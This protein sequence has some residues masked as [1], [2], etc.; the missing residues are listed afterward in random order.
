MPG[1]VPSSASTSP[2]KIPRQRPGPT[3]QPLT[4]PLIVPGPVPSSASTPPLKIPRRCPGP[5]GQPLATP[6]IVPGPVPSSASTPPSKIP[7]R[8]PGPS[9][10]PLATPLIVPGPVPSSANTPPLKKPRRRP[11]PSGQPL[12]EVMRGPVNIRN[13]LMTIDKE[14]DKLCS[15]SSHVFRTPPFHTSDFSWTD[16]SNKLSHLTPLFW[17][18]LKQA[19]ASTSDYKRKTSATLSSEVA[20]CVLAAAILLK[21]RNIH[22]SSLAVSQFVA[23][24]QLNYGEYLINVIAHAYMQCAQSNNKNDRKFD[25]FSFCTDSGASQPPALGCCT[26]YTVQDCRYFI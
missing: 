15:K 20:T 18:I 9:G 13:V 7:R 8:H 1:P 12:A 2:S 3:G 24:Q 21:S 14:C 5:T 11:G 10:Q 26:T 23:W 22:L 17:A 6:L 19:A 25:L 16:Y 4:T